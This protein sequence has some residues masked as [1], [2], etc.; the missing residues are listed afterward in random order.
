MSA[1]KYAALP[2]RKR[3]FRCGKQRTRVSEHSHTEL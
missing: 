1:G 2:W 3:G